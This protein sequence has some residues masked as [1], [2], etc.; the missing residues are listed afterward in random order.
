M[1]MTIKHDINDDRLINYSEA[2]PTHRDSQSHNNQQHF[3][4]IYS[5]M[6]KSNF[7]QYARNA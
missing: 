1:L 4:E 6:Y 2:P 7:T 5:L 3:T